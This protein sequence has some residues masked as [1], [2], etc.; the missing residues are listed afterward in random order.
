[1]LQETIGATGAED[2]AEILVRQQAGLR[3]GR[4]ISTGEAALLGACDGDLTLA[5]L[6]AAVEELTGESVG[7]DT[8][9][10]LIAEGWLGL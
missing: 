1:V 4:S 9:R 8:V 2:P 6:L 10:G 7:L 3:R 5:Q